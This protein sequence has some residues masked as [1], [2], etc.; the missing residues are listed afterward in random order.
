MITTISPKRS[1]Y[2]Q[3]LDILKFA[4]VVKNIKITPKSYIVDHNID[5]LSGSI[6]E[7]EETAEVKAYLE[8][9]NKSLEALY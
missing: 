7:T 9:L 6:H 4:E 5:I 1:D 2:D 3:T 8:E